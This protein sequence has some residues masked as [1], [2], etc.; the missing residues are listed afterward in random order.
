MPFRI[1]SSIMSPG[2]TPIASRMCFG[3]MTRP[4]LS[5]FSVVVISCIYYKL[6][7]IVFKLFLYLSIIAVIGKN[8][9][10]RGKL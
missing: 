2:A 6:P 3:I 10:Y 4:M 7:F 9:A 5:I 1:V 8:D